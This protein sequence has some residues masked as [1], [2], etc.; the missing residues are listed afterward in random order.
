[1]ITQVHSTT[2]RVRGKGSFVWIRN[3]VS[4]T[5]AV[6]LGFFIGGQSA[7][8]T[9]PN[10][11]LQ[12][13]WN[14]DS[15]RFTAEVRKVPLPWVLGRLVRVTGWHVFIEPGTERWVDVAF[16]NL[17]PSVALPRLLG[18][19]NF[20]LIP[21][22]KN[23]WMLRIYKSRADA[24]TRRID[25]LDD[26]DVQFQPGPIPNELIVRL[27]SGSKLTPEELARRLGAKLVGR[28]DDLRTYRLR[29]ET[30]ADAL[31]ARDLLGGQTEIA[32]VENNA[33]LAIPEPG[34]P[35]GFAG[36][37]VTLK[38]RVGSPK[39]QVVVALIDTAVQ[40]LPA[41]LEPFL[42]DRVAV[43]GGTAVNDGS[44][45]HGT[46]MYQDILQG[47]GRTDG[48]AEGTKVRILSVDVYGSEPATTTWN[49]VR[50]LS[51]A[52]SRG[53]TVFNLSL[54]GPQDSTLLDEVIASIRAQGGIVLAATGN[55]P[56]T[57]LTYPSA[58]PGALGVTAVDRNGVPAD[59]ANTGPQAR[60][61]GPG[62]T[63]IQFGGQS[64]MANGT[65]GATAWVSGLAAGW[66][67]QSGG[68]A[69]QAANWL[70]SAVPFKSTLPGSP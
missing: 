3:A 66:M 9:S 65:S 49:V 7:A 68:S 14:G 42:L 64:W 21:E 10:G 5:N 55:T 69:I 53:A 20:A 43:A 31:R 6:F 24:A 18:P 25:P 23:P 37:D 35:G 38:P 11:P 27:R 19:L 33:R 22:G 58:S 56:G 61:A 17:P 63:V 36:S 59:Y 16:T 30:E 15:A 4:W 8:E 67:S 13:Q 40:T 28:L 54:G 26:G 70:Q 29:F 60:L 12:L 46:V 51:E 62:S 45:T 34:Q 52:A 39:D 44:P 50:G 1:M 47:V 2:R 41:G 57:A 32:A 48:S